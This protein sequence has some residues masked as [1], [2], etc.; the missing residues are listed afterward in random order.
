[1][2]RQSMKMTPGIGL[3]VLLTLSQTVGLAFHCG[4]TAGVGLM[5]L[6]PPSQVNKGEVPDAVNGDE[7]TASFNLERDY[8]MLSA[9][10]DATGMCIASGIIAQHFH[11]AQDEES[12]AHWRTLSQRDCQ[13]ADV[14]GKRGR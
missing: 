2:K 4:D 13:A 11:K 6:K 5:P 8:Q 1:M 9:H 3:L 7:T 10:H 14:D 12:E